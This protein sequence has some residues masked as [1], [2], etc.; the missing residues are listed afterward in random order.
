LKL[1]F[2]IDGAEDTGGTSRVNGVEFV[3]SRRS[4]AQSQSQAQSPGSESITTTLRDE[5]NNAFT[6]GGVDDEI[7]SILEGGW[8]GA[9]SGNSATVTLNGLEVGD[10][11][12]VQLFASDARA[13]SVVATLGSARSPRTAPPRALT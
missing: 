10:V 2:A 6:H 8:F 12:E 11:Y 13:A 5:E 9:A 3:S 1:V 7:G 4:N